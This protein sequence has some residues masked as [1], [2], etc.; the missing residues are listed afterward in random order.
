MVP[1]EG[2]DLEIGRLVG[3]GPAECEVSGGGPPPEGQWDGILYVLWCPLK[4][5]IGEVV[6]VSWPLRPPIKELV[7]TD[8]TEELWSVAVRLPPRNVSNWCHG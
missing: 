6:L 2:C 3:A 1:A 4:E 8:C 5:A 7:M